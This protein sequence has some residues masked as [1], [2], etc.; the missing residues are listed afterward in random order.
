MFLHYFSAG[1]TLPIISLYL[2]Q[3]LGFGGTGA[4]I[5]LSLS[6]FSA[7]VAPLA[8]AF[9]TDRLVSAERLFAIT[10]LAAGLFI[11]C[12]WWSTGYAAVLVFYF[13]YMS[14]LVPAIALSNAIVFHHSP[15]M[16]NSF[17]GIRLW[18]TVGWVAA[19]WL[20]SYFWIELASGSVAEAP[21]FSAAVAVI[22]GLVALTLPRGNGV[23]PRRR[24]LIP[25]AA[26]RVMI[27]PE[28]ALLAVAALMMQITHRTYYFGA[29]PY[30]RHLGFSDGVMLPVLS[31]GQISEV[32]GMLLLPVLFRRFTYRAVL[33]LG[34]VMELIRFG[35]LF[36][37][38]TPATAFLG[39]LFHGPAYAFFFTVAF[40]YINTQADSESRA[41]VQQFFVLLME[42]VGALGGSLLAGALYDHFMRGGVVQYDLF[43]RVP[44]L[45]TGFSICLLVL[46]HV[47]VR[48]R[49]APE[50]RR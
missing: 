38:S 40:I 49:D 32:L 24:D 25:R 6:A 8:G 36:A 18:G 17:G 7:F 45:L 30:L 3:E 1:L 27:R 11:F 10:E 4:G 19:G 21:L 48:L 13:L 2:S 46:L 29:A 44:F 22:L 35:W 47:V 26:F 20:F 33:L 37:G 23:V 50:R 31:I 12:L 43:W 14:M 5:I 9:V 34:T 16:G 15:D 28:I 39:I 42:G 41:G